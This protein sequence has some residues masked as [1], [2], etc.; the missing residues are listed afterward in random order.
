MVFKSR[1]FAATQVVDHWIDEKEASQITGMS[2]SWFQR[3]R[4]QGGGIP[5][6]K[7]K[8][9]CRY[10]VHDIISWME[11]RKTNSTSKPPQAPGRLSGRIGHD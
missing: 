10:K 1:V 6:T 3:M 2:R 11:S 8:R 7:A 5:Y 9:A 4:W